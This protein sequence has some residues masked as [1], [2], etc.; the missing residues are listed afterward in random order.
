MQT[1]IKESEREDKKKGKQQRK[2]F[3]QEK[4]TASMAEKTPNWI[5]FSFLTSAVLG[6]IDIFAQR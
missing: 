2:Y 6:V 1:Q 5:P 3:R 4:L